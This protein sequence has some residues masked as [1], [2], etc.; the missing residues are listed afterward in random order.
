[1]TKHIQQHVIPR[2]P[3]LQ[4]SVAHSRFRY[5]S[6]SQR[7]S[8]TQQTYTMVFGLGLLL[9]LAMLGFFYLQ[10]VLDTASRG[11]DIHALEERLI[12]L[13]GKQRDLELEGAELRSI[14][15]IEEKIQGLHLVETKEV[16]YLGGTRQQVAAAPQL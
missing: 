16:T 10:Q 13:K 7:G 2:R 11:T 6:F 15:T 8:M 12:Q 4:S 3:V 1:M 14:Q 9:F 5:A